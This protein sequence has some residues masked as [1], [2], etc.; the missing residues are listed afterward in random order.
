MHNVESLAVAAFQGGFVFVYAERAQGEESTNL[1]WATFDPEAL[2]FGAFS[3]VKFDKPDPGANRPVVG[4]EF[5]DAKVLN[6]VAAYDPGKDGGP[7]TST[8]WRVGTLK[9]IE[10]EAQLVLDASPALIATLDGFK[11][12]SVTIDDDGQ[13]YIGTDDE[14][15][16]N[17]LRPLR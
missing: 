3:S 1:H 2:T 14:N 7:F 5:D 10:G 4:L 8:L 15:L 11:T 17:V 6:S 9:A 12:E 13:I 16:G